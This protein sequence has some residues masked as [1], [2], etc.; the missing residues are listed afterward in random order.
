MSAAVDHR[1]LTGALLAGSALLAVV[2]YAVLGTAFGWPDVLDEPGTTALDRYV[3]AES[4]VRAGFYA[5]SL[6]SLALVPAAFGV[7]EL[8][9]RDDAVARSVTAFGVLGAFAQL[10]GWLRWVVAVPV[11]ADLWTAATDPQ[12]RY[13]VAAAYDTLNAY[14]GGTLG[15]HLGWLLQGLWAIGIAAM[16][17]RR[18]GLPRWL[19]VPGLVL[20]ATWAPLTALGT[21][22]DVALAETLGVGVLYTAWYVWLLVL[23]VALLVRTSSPA[24]GP[25]GAPRAWSGAPASSPD[26]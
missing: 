12:Q 11:Q 22:A 16:A 18:S 17:L 20:A 8:L 15:E 10:L 4:A 26:R 3:E 9:G 14:A 23:G 13:A 5:M 7:H 25:V 19:T 24:G 2:G 21:A 6:A 1:R